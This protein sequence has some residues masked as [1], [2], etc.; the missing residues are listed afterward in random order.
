LDALNKMIYNTIYSFF[1]F[2]YFKK[3]ERGDEQN[4]DNNHID[5]SSAA[6]T[7]RREYFLFS[8]RIVQI[9]SL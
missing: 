3:K 8:E 7:G 1:Y 6:G 2:N 9:P 4:I 5:I